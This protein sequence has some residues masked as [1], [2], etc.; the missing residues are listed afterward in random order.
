MSRETSP[1]SAEHE[2]HIVAAQI[3]RPLRAPS[4]AARRCHLGLPVVATVPPVLANGEPFP[5]RF[6]LSCPLAHRRIARL[7]AAGGVR[8]ADARAGDDAAFAASLRDAH[9]RYATERDA[10]LPRD[11]RLAPRGG[12]GGSRGG[13]KCLH[14]HYAHHAAGR[15]TA[16]GAEVAARIEPLDCA[17]PCVTSAGDGFRRDP[18]WSEPALDARAPSPDAGA[19]GS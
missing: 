13:V 4:R 8:A 12:V 5:T 14:A 19:H 15:L 1:K 16:L 7:E 10:L 2:A 17:S 9:A 18:A 11:A 3:G 6:W